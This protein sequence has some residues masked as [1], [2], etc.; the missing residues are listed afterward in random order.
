V[1]HCARCVVPV[2]AAPHQLEY[3]SD[4]QAIAENGLMLALFNLGGG[5]IILIL[6]LVVI[7]FVADQVPDA[8][9]RL[10]RGLFRFWNAANN[11]ASDAGRSLGGVFGKRAVQALAPDNQVAELYTPGAF[12]KEREPRRT[13]RTVGAVA[14]ETV[15]RDGEISH[16][17]VRA[18]MNL[19]PAKLLPAVIVACL[20]VQTSCVRSTGDAGGQQSVSSARR[21]WSATDAAELAARLAN[22][23]CK[24]QFGRHPFSPGQHSAILEH[25]LYHWGKLD[26]GGV[27]G[28]SAV[29]TFRTDGAKPH[30]EVYFS[31]D[32]MVVR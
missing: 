9:R 18:S 2:V 3:T 19:G 17:P 24:H 32:T 8:S 27:G 15:A 30:V 4:M 12:E 13:P 21:I 28:F 29:V 1:Q 5:E 6:A 10:G 20:L 14:E 26:V 25:G 16:R 11:E 7:L 22:E 31:S 23:Q